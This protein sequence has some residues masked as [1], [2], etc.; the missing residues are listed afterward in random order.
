MNSAATYR[1]SSVSAASPDMDEAESRQ[2]VEDIRENGQLVPIVKIGNEVVDGRKRLR[3]CEELG[4]EPKV[5]DLSGQDPEQ[6]SYS[7]NILRTHYTTGQRAMFAARRANLAPRQKKSDLAIARSEKPVTQ[8]EAAG[9]AAVHISDVAAAKRIRREAAPEVVA[10]VEAGRLTL[11]S[12]KKIVASL[13]LTEQPAAV[14]SV[15]RAA[16]GKKRQ[17]PVSAL[18]KLAG[19][20]KRT[21]ASPFRSLAGRMDRGIDQ[22][23]TAV[24]LLPGFVA[25]DGDVHNPKWT[26]RLC[27]AR[28]V[29]GRVIDSLR[30][31]A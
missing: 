5:I 28:T 27:A 11:H 21:N 26:K 1:I 25:E 29:L 31:R 22:L 15:V 6:L 3:A 18:A 7:L 4:I 23:E 10:A 17:T 24:E 16:R 9:E 12:A 19:T 30:R 20:P 2:L 14:E 8:A 13:P